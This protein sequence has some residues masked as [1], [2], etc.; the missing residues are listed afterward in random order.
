MSWARGLNLAERTAL[1]V[2]PAQPGAGGDRARRRLARWQRAHG[3]GDGG[4]FAVM[5]EALGTT[6]AGLLALL[7]E[8]PSEL[9]RR[10]AAPPDWANPIYVE[11]LPSARPVPEKDSKSFWLSGFSRV[12]SP[13]VRHA[14]DDLEQ[15]LLAHPV[16]EA[17]ALGPVL[18]EITASLA[19]D[20]VTTATRTLV[21]ELNVM[22][23]QG[24]L[25]GDTAADRFWSFVD[26]TIKQR[27]ALFD[28][29]PVLA[30]L[31]AR[32]AGTCVE[33][34]WEFFQRWWED[35]EL[36]GAGRIEA[37]EFGLGD[38]HRGGRT[39]AVVRLDSGEK[40]VYKPRPLGAHVHFNSLLRWLNGIAGGIELRQLSIVDRGGYG[41]VEFAEHFEC[42]DAAEV[43]R[44]YRR[45]GALM[46]LLYTLDGADFHFENLVASGGQPV[47]VDLETLFHQRLTPMV[48]G[49]EIANDPALGALD[50]SVN[51]LGLLPI[52]VTGKESTID[53]GG[54]GGDPAGTSPFPVPALQDEGTDTMRIVRRHTEFAS[55]QNRPAA[56]G[57]TADPLDHMEQLLDGFRLAYRA[58]GAHHGELDGMLDRF[59]GAEVRI[60]LRPTQVYASLLAEGN[61]PVLLRDA[62]DYDRHL[63]LLWADCSRRPELTRI[64][65]HELADLWAGDVPIF[66]ARPGSRDLWTSSGH[67]LPEC[68]PD[69]ALDRVRAK[70][71]GFGDDDLAR[72]EWMI[73]AA[74]VTRPHVPVVTRT[75]APDVAG[76][77]LHGDYLAAAKRIGDK[78]V[79]LSISDSEGRSSWL[80]LTMAGDA[81]WR[82]EALGWDFYSGS[83]G[84]ALFLHA[85]G[86][87][88]GEPRYAE[89][90]SRALW[91]LP[92]V[93]TDLAGRP[94]GNR[95]SGLTGLPGLA[96]ALTHMRL[97]T[98]L[99]RVV[100]LCG[101]AVD[102]DTSFDILKGSAGTIA[103]MLAVHAHT[104]SGAAL[105]VAVRC[106]E[107][108]LAHS[109]PVGA[110]LTWPAAGPADQPLTGFSHG[111]G[112]I[113]WALVRLGAATGEQRFVDAGLAAFRYERAEFRAD[114]GNWPDFRT[115]HA[116]QDGH[117]FAWCHGAG[118]IGLARADVLSIVD[119]PGVRDDLDLAVAAIAGH[120]FGLNHSQCH[121]DTGN[122]EL[123]LVTGHDVSPVGARLLKELDDDGPR[124]G[125][126]SGVQTPSLM[127]G[128][129]G[130]GYGLL[131]LAAP[132]R[133]PSILLAHTHGKGN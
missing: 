98:H 60:V 21:L 110:A 74:L 91:S 108:L 47:I 97:P 131:R 120:G 102:A 61:H 96:Y 15:R 103:A 44:Y 13:F 22:R 113:G 40:F 124:C 123:L 46:A 89:T 112:G 18:E 17:V 111:A 71:A 100:R 31:L 76:K 122:L 35:R 53:L 48:G 132:E 101:E 57:V 114:W 62:L 104:G 29:Y 51:R 54:L 72:Q 58:I 45:L 5:L 115:L 119:D 87:L 93:L 41:W 85:L 82:V 49:A 10:A 68:F 11:L 37:V 2:P 84:V 86:E 32:Q 73:T 34:V 59:A 16:H 117:M 39:V 43:N 66:T 42:A 128:L 19:G 107:R 36:L 92:G 24:G 33:A 129:A 3:L 63:S 9:A 75:T 109:V 56:G 6:E 80:G 23:V 27:E 25:T 118:G 133:V 127:T 12:I 125:T 77:P 70:L 8:Q 121:G 30:R 88:T 79:E 95:G 130:I 105:K 69:S 55:G 126:P 64:V 28:E 52:L 90:A 14:I 7:G 94:A 1:P 81:T 4:G 65:P 106:G 67:R 50:A 83:S 78:L 38:P 99:E 116:G 26:A 20:L